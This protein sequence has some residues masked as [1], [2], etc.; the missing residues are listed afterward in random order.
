MDYAYLVTY[1]VSQPGTDNEHGIFICDSKETAD[2]KFDGLVEEWKNAL[3]LTGDDTCD[4]DEPQ[5]DGAVRYASING[6][7]THVN[8]GLSKQK[9]L[10][11]QFVEYVYGRDN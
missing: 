6:D 7:G 11:K 5:D 4:V 10:T 2:L 1:T 8:I 9:V 3:C